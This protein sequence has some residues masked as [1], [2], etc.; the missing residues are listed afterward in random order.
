MALLRGGRGNVASTLTLRLNDEV[1]EVEEMMVNPWARW[2][3]ARCGGERARARRSA[4]RRWQRAPPPRLA[5]QREGKERMEREA[6]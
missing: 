6:N 4:R 5:Q 1:D 2:N 3:E